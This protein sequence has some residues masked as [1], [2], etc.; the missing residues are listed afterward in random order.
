MTRR[1]LS[2]LLLAALVVGLLPLGIVSVSA[3]D[4]FIV[5][6]VE[7]GNVY[8]DKMLYDM[9][10]GSVAYCDDTITKAVIPAQIDGVAVTTIGDYAFSAAAS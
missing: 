4:A 5:Y 1:I 9:G 6:P 3:D 8:F 10:I 7:G 2:I